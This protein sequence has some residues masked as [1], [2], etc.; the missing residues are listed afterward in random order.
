MGRDRS[1][2]TAIDAQ[3]LAGI[4]RNGSEQ[5]LVIDCRTFTEYNTLHVTGSVNVCCSKIVKRRLQQDKVAAS[6]EK[7]VV[8]YDQSTQDARTSSGEFVS[9]VLGKLE[10]SFRCV[11]LLEGG[12][13]EFSSRFPGLCE[14][15]S[16]AII[17]SSISQPCLSTS[18]VAL[19]RILPH[20][21]L[22]SQND[23]L[24]K[25][26]MSQNGITHVL[27]VSNSC[28]KPAYIAESHFLRIPV[29]DS[30]CE[31]ILPWIS[32]SM[33]FIDKVKMLNG[34]VLVHCLAG[35]SRSAAVAIA[36]IMKT[37]GLSL[38]DAYRFVKERRPT[39][40]P[41]FN[42]LGQLLEY[43][44]SLDRSRPTVLLKQ[45]LS[46]T[47]CLTEG[48]NCLEHKCMQEHD[49]SGSVASCHQSLGVALE[50]AEDALEVLGGGSEDCETHVSD[51]VL[52]E[53]QFSRLATEQHWDASRMKRS[54]SLDIK[55]V[56]PSASLSTSSETTT[57]FYKA[58]RPTD[59]NPFSRLFGLRSRVF[60]LGFFSLFANGSGK[61]D[62]PSHGYE[63][64]QPS[65]VM[66]GERGA[67]QDGSRDPF[68]LTVPLAQ[69][70][71]PRTPNAAMAESPRRPFFLSMPSCKQQAFA[72][73]TF[74]EMS[75]P[76]RTVTSLPLQ[77]Q[78]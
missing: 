74:S 8:V 36:Y 48:R 60:G 55:S 19:T 64:L 24:N 12:F 9:V 51:V 47:E 77:G 66:A 1:P 27:N 3:G 56:Y 73:G 62:A 7:Q 54:F 30:Y 63:Q 46:H 17:H 18:N 75:R 21:Y 2:P 71:L 38:D 26:V 58:S 67:S 15:K 41:N 6:S 20:L 43:E 45:A 50:P 22:G 40:S 57:D 28:P 69:A 53:G 76:Q 65:D 44:M 49:A 31:K 32:G 34:R 52:L 13:A 37:L 11:S 78:T 68:V 4:L 14:G 5:V 59:T 61:R 10:K 42:F 35:I 72:K 70:K 25:E 23:V 33:E 16:S 29:N 39:I